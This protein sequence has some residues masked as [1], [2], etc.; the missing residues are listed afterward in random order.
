M[1]ECLNP[2]SPLI[3]FRPPVDRPTTSFVDNPVIDHLGDNFEH[4]PL[5]QGRP[6]HIHT[7]SVAIRCL[8][9]GEGVISNLPHERGPLP[10]GIQEGDEAMQMA[11]LDDEWEFGD[12]TSGIVAAMAEADALEPT[13]KEAQSRFNWPEWKKA[14]QIELD[15]L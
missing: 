9:I 1:R 12:V 13:Y 15:A 8:R 7:E 10:R 3:W 6:R 2:S 4:A 14:I 5:D 11:E